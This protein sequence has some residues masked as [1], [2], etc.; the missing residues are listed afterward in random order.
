MTEIEQLRADIEKLENA[1]PVAKRLGGQATCV[2]L[3][4]FKSEIEFELAKLEAEAAA[5]ADRW[6]AAKKSL[7]AFEYH[8]KHG[9]TNSIVHATVLHYARHLEQRVAEL[10]K[11]L[12]SEKQ[13]VHNVDSVVYVL[14]NDL[15]KAQARIAELEAQLA[16]RPKVYCVKTHDGIA[17]TGSRSKVPRVFLAESIEDEY[18]DGA[19]CIVPYTGQ[20]S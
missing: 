13:Q 16:K 4:A 14:S 2:T 12:A 6:A 1:M 3:G 11:Q 19:Q 17:T 15:K 20:Q 8:L 18:G 5:K 10:E 7:D 9:G